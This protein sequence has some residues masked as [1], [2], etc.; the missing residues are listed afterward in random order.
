MRK[1]RKLC[2]FNGRASLRQII[3][4]WLWLFVAA[5]LSRDDP[6]E[7]NQGAYV[8]FKIHPPQGRL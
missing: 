7:P 3:D 8:Q 6:G 4:A 1:E 5:G 2:L